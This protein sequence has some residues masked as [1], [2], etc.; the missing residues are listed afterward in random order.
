MH[1]H[2]YVRMFLYATCYHVR[3][4]KNYME[5]KM[6]IDTVNNKFRR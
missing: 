4:Y 5:A 2:M 3:I 1:V 6:Y